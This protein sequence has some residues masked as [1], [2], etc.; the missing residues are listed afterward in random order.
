[1]EVSRNQGPDNNFLQQV[2]K[3]CN[4]NNIILIF[5][6]CTSGFRQTY[7][8]LHK[9]YKVEPDMAMFGKALGNGYA[10]TAVIGKDEIMS[11]AQESFISSTF[12][13]ERVGPTAAL[14]TLK[15]MK[16]TRSWKKITN[17]GNYLIK[18]WKSRR[19]IQSRF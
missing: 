15:E 10:I 1:M 8:G 12:W 6:E 4:K 2:R 14:A 16:R 5:D 18:G 7:G 11:E 19:K 17:L 3:L 13:T 9:F